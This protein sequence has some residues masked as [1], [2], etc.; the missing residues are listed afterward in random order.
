MRWHMKDVVVYE[1]A[2]KTGYKT[3]LLRSPA[4]FSAMES[5]RTSLVV[6]RN[7]RANE[8][9]TAIPGP[10][11]P[12]LASAKSLAVSQRNQQ[13]QAPILL[14]CGRRFKSVNHLCF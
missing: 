2:V 1:V 12:P 5:K 3:T 8:L 9:G 13:I 4:Q 10:D 7:Q 6:G 14:I 11:W